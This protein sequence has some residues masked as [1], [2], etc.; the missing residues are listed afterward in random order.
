VATEDV[1]VAVILYTAPYSYRGSDRL[2]ITRAGNDKK[3]TIGAVLAPS[4][5][6]LWP[7][8]RAMKTDP[9]S[10]FARYSE[11]YLAELSERWKSQRPMWSELIKLEQVTMV[12][13][14]SDPARCH[15]TQAAGFLVGVSEGRINYAG[16]RLPAQTSL[17][18]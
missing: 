6:I 13:F 16:E 11:Q 1:D 18:G 14:C 2:D 17:F 9:S 7:A 10:A 4:A 3:W 5:A 12:C 8:L 15:R